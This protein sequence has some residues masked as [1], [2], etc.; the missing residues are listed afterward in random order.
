M[1]IRFNY[2]RLRDICWAKTKWFERLGNTTKTKDGTNVFV[3]NDSSVLAIAH[4]DVVVSQKRFHVLP[5]ADKITIICPQL[6]DRLGIYVIMDILPRL[7]IKPDILLTE[8]E[9]SGKSTA[10]HFISTKK[11]NWVFSFDRMGTDVVCYQFED[12]PTKKLLEENGFEVGLG[13]FSDISSLHQL[14]CKAFNFGVGYWGQ[15]SLMSYVEIDDTKQMI[16]LFRKFWDK[17][18][19]THL[20]HDSSMEKTKW[21]GYYSYGRWGGYKDYT[22]LGARKVYTGTDYGHN[23]ELTDGNNGDFHQPYMQGRLTSFDDEE[24]SDLDGIVLKWP[25]EDVMAILLAVQDHGLELEIIPSGISWSDVTI[26]MLKVLTTEK[27]VIY[28][29]EMD[30]EEYRE[31]LYHS[32]YLPE[33][34]LETFMWMRD[35]V[36]LPMDSVIY[37]GEEL[38]S[39][40]IPPTRLTKSADEDIV[41]RALAILKGKEQEKGTKSTEEA[42]LETKL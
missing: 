32:E 12:D 38:V 17:M 33:E 16:R 21:G 31:I 4:R 15:H 20:L 6:D 10:E 18:K 39:P 2:N 11:Y 27:E 26:D 29:A 40:V 30:A 22:T 13:S 7:G 19:N 36:W 5:F 34:Y 8:G 23:K 1:K 24:E 35:N 25:A 41:N 42:T 37:E 3:D 9:E 14:G 28:Q